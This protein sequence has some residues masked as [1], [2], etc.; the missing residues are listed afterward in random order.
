[1]TSSADL[2]RGPIVAI[3]NT[4][5]GSC[6]ASS[7]GQAE[8]LFAAEGLAD[9]DVVAVTPDRLSDAL[10]AAV[11]KAKV[12]IVLGGDG[13]IGTAATRC[14]ETGPLLIPLPG[15]TMNMLPKA[16]YGTSDWR[17][18]LTA[19]LAAPRLQTVSGGELAGHRF[20]CAAILGAPSLWADAREAVREGHL[21][22]AAQ[23]AVTATRR[24]LSDAVDFDF[25]ET[26]GSGDAVAVI[27]PLVSDALTGHERALEAVALDLKTATALFGLAF[28]AAYD[29]WRNDPSVIR[30]TTRNVTVTGHGALPTILDGEKVRIGR[31]AEIRFLP[32]AFRALVPTQAPLG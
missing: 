23:K 5:S 15:G 20:Y 28:H 31:K 9:V 29:G 17:E 7:A 12:L 18:A 10:D 14:G 24:S 6:D 16:L 26:S 21:L 19:T 25:G 11:A 13:T 3:L 27:C 8:A 30:V 4:G 22:D 32:V 1:M 2:L